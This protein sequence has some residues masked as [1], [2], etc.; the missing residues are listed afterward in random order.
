M[1]GVN[2]RYVASSGR[3]YNLKDR[4]LRARSSA[5]FHK[6][7]WGINSVALQYGSRVSAF[8]R[9]AVVYEAVLSL[10]GTSESRLKQLEALHND[11]ELDARNMT[12]GRLY[13]ND[14]YINCYATKSTTEPDDSNMVVNN[15]ISF[16]CPYPFWIKE[17]KVVLAEPDVSSGNFLDYPYDYPYD[18]TAPIMGERIVASD[19][20]FESEFRMVIYGAAVNPR[21]TIN[22]YPYVLYTTISQGSY[23]VID[24]KA[25]TVMMYGSGGVKTNIFDLRNKTNSIFK[26]IPPGNLSIAWDASFGV[27]LT[28]FRERSEPEFEEVQ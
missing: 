18:Y 14:F 22:G 19:F 2:L 4:T 3:S 17:E 7:E 11:F 1:S 9:Q 21:I 13:W 23:A 25:K 10:F 20:P 26:K 15:T 28:I 5:I 24:S 27:D 12:P 8:T 16:Y 6:W